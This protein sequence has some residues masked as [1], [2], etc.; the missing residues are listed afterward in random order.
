MYP[1]SL[2]YGVRNSR[3]LATGSSVAATLSSHPV[4]P[5][6]NPWEHAWEPERAAKNCITRMV[7][8]RRPGRIRT[9]LDLVRT[10]TSIIFRIVC[11][12][13]ELTIA[14]R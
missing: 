2:R 11:R 14:L 10:G 8:G 12:A 1:G 13:A 7:T 3:L 4:E 9:V 5:E 6:K